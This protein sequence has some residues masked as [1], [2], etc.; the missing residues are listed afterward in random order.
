MDGIAGKINKKTAIYLSSHFIHSPPLY[1]IAVI[2]G[3][4]CGVFH[5]EYWSLSGLDVSLSSPCACSHPPVTPVTNNRAPASH[6]GQSFCALIFHLVWG[7]HG[8]R[9]CFH[10]CRALQ[11]LWLLRGVLSLPC[12][13]S[14]FRF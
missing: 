1:R 2:N 6:N 14:L 8:K 9:T 10:R 13:R 3:T 12:A 7:S 11:V 4:N 5:H